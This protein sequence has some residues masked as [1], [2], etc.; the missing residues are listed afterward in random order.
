[1]SVEGSE[2]RP[3]GRL[4]DPRSVAI[5]GASERRLDVVRTVRRG[6]RSWLVNPRRDEL[7]GTECHASVALLPEVPDAAMILVGAASVEEA[8]KEA[9]DA[10]VGALVVPGLGSEAGGAARALAERVAALAEERQVPLL[11]VNCMGYA[12]PRGPSLWL[13]TPGPNFEPGRVA[14][15]SQSGSVAEAMAT[16]GRRVGFEV[17]VSS[18]SEVTRDAADL[19]AALAA[20]EATGVIGLFLESVRRPAAFAAA[21][22]RCARAD[23]PVL[24][25]KVGRSAA[26]AAAAL[27]HT[28]AVVGSSVAFGALLRAYGAI[29][30]DDVT[31]LVEHLEVFG[32]SR[33]PQGRR[34]CAVSESGGEAGLLADRASSVGLELPA[35]PAQVSRTLRD[36]FPNF[37]E[38]SNP[39]DAWAVD[40]VAKVFPRS[41]EL[42]ATGGTCDILVGLVE[43]TRFRS[44]ADLAWC[45]VVVRALAAIAGP[46]VFPALISTTVTDPD[47]ALLE[48]ARA[49]DV[50]VLRGVG[51]AVAALSAAVGWTPRVPSSRPEAEPTDISDLLGEGVL[52]EWESS[53]LLARYGVR[54]ASSERAAGPEEAAAAAQRLGL[55]VVVKLDG[56]AHKS[57]V[58]GVV[59]GLTSP[60]EAA[61]AAERLGGPVLVARQVQGGLEVFCGMRRDPDFGPVV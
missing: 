53:Q 10:G 51:P 31:D 39:L 4:L 57:R 47:E 52:P 43:L 27:T 61:A 35:L 40:D 33:R 29:E 7:D 11:G 12:R 32:R 36:E 30:L 58:G 24:C 50:A 49:G 23:K 54:F 60:E 3:L 16:L 25:V 34:L 9:L 14:V 44:P 48:L 46:E 45:A 6:V 19:V 15:V 13:G 28:G 18:G 20:D 38:P 5:V 21:L 56:P 17:V 2:L 41:I 26:A 42:L 1:M 55:P 37:S 8:T 22:E 59:V